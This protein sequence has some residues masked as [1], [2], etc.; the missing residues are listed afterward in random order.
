MSDDDDDD[1]PEDRGR[2][3]RQPAQARP[4]SGSTGGEE[5]DRGTARRS[6]R[7]RARCCAVQHGAGRAGHGAARR[8]VGRRDPVEPRHRGAGGGPPARPSDE[9]GTHF[10]PESY[11]GGERTAEHPRGEV[12]RAA[13]RGP[14]HP[15]DARGAVGFCVAYFIVPE[16]DRLGQLMNY[17]LGGGLAVA[18]LALGAGFVLW[19]KKLL[20]HDKAVQERH[21]FHSPEEEELRRRGDLLQGRRADRSRQPQDPAPLTARHRRGAAAARAVC[22]CRTSARCRRKKLRPQ[23]LEEG[24]PARRRDDQAAGQARRPRDRRHQDRH[25]R[26]VHHRPRSSPL[27]PTMLI[28]FASGR[29]PLGAG[30]SPGRSTTTS[31]TRRSARTPAA[32]SASTSSRRTTCCARATSRRSTWPT[33]PTSS[34]AR[35]RDACRRCRSTSTPR[36]TSSRRATT[37]SLWARASGSVAR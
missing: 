32:R 7:S 3:R 11:Y 19:A 2:R 14:V 29:D 23:R 1:G 26:G 10:L 5:R 8:K 16:H 35:L 30:S 22:C 36:A 27:A 24:R 4:A 18:L 34:S 9:E 28:R 15:R 21:A 17:A 37:T 20:P 13:G 33:T 25:A 31:R 12:R 6:T